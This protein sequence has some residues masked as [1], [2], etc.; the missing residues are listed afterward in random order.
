MPLCVC[1]LWCVRAFCQDMRVSEVMQPRITVEALEVNAT[2][3]DFLHLVNETKY[4][5]I[6]V[7]EGEIDRIV[8]VAIVKDVLT[9]AMRPELHRSMK[10]GDLMEPTYFV[11][12]SMRAQA[13]LEEMRR[14][15]LPVSACLR[16]RE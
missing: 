16:K 11:P 8:G 14:F 3:L 15:V 7:Y 4:S 1:V 10:V 5:R 12:E 2:L 6:P 13:V 9:F